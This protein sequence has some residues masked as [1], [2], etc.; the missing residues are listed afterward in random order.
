MRL[1]MV[2]QRRPSA[3][4]RAL[5]R[6]GNNLGNTVA[7]D[8]AFIGGGHYNTNS[9]QYSTVSKQVKQVLTFDAGTGP[10]GG[11]NSAFAFILVSMV[12]TRF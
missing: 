4:A 5:D 1:R 6:H 10:Y 2:P 11:S 9:G 7:A 8:G 3:P 12:R